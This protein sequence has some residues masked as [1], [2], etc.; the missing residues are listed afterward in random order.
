V[1]GATIVLSPDAA[2][3]SKLEA[4]Y[5]VL[6]SQGSLARG[7]LTGAAQCPAIKIGTASTP[8]SV[9]AKPD[10]GSNPAFPVLVC[11]ALIAPNASS[12]SIEGQVLSLPN[13]SLKA[14]AVFGDTGCR[15]KASKKMLR[16]EADDDQEPGTFQDCDKQSKWPFSR[17]SNTLAALKPDL[18]IHVG[19]Y[20]YRESP[21]PKGE[22]GCKDSP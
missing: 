15:L 11:E 5:V 8:M 6:G 22:Q 12:A 19:D 7:I 14:I 21:C 9:R 10:T 20:P 3:S 2:R 4:A 1:V 16:N 13:T 18:V 17:L